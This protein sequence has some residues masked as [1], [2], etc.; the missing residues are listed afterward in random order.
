LA[1][2]S[3]SA[4]PLNKRPAPAAAASSGRASPVMEPALQRAASSS[5]EQQLEKKQARRD[6]AGSSCRSSDGEIWR[7]GV[8]AGSPTTRSLML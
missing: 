1:E 4:K 2:L 5:T 3:S 7:D 6:G 8:G